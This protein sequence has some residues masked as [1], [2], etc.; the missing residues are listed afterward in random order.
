MDYPLGQLAPSSLLTAK[1]FYGGMQLH[2]YHICR[3]RNKVA[4]NPVVLGG[5]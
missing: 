3:I 1:M 5:M 2:L 4:T